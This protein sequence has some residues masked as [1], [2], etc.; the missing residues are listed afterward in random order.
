[1]PLAASSSPGD[2]LEALA[3]S[4]G[5]HDTTSGLFAE[6]RDSY[7]GQA[8]SAFCLKG[9]RSLLGYCSKVTRKRACVVMQNKMHPKA[10]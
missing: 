4:V 3:K 5:C 10:G 6:V 9:C 2:W 7:A 8:C 1:M